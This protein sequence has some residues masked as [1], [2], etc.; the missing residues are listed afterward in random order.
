MGADV[1]REIKAREALKDIRSGMTDLA[2]MDKYRIT[3]RG[4]RSLFRK[5][6]AAGLLNPREIE[7]RDGT[8]V[9]TV[10]LD[11]EDFGPMK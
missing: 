5:L 3:D 8:F 6:L 2:L 4:L 7:N 9:S 10:T 11:L 1:K